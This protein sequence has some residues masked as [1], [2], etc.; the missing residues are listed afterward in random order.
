MDGVMIDSEPI[1]MRAFEILMGEFGLKIGKE[2]FLGLVGKRSIDNFR[3]LRVTYALPA[4]AEQLNERK[5]VLYRDILARGLRDE[6]YG[7]RE[8]LSSL[9][10]GLRAAGFLLGVASS[11]PE[12]DIRIVVEG[13][14][15]RDSFTVFASGDE[16]PRGKP[17]PDV[18]LLAARRLGVPPERCAVIEDSEPGVLAARNAGMV[19]VA[20]PGEFTAAQ[21]F[22]RAHHRVE[23]L[24]ELR[25][26]TFAD[27]IDRN[28]GR[29]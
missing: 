28:G 10:K 12:E 25:A 15:V 8:G 3:E 14:G 4:T 24:T 20:A 29:T 2:V 18:F 7:E 9:L 26:E 1:Q 21:D 6:T 13:L 19:A 27:L 11:S 17:D 16:V 22:S 5:N 23:A